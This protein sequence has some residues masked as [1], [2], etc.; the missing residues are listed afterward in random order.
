MGLS[1]RGGGAERWDGGC[2][3]RGPRA[4]WKCVIASKTLASKLTQS[5][6]P[7]L[8]GV[9]IADGDAIAATTGGSGGDTI[10]SGVTEFLGVLGRLAGFLWIDS[11]PFG[12]DRDPPIIPSIPFSLS[13]N[14]L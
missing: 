8:T 13:K 9:A 14:F 5:V 11:M 10:G 6:F 4:S 2:T 1:D 3:I 12:S 7:A